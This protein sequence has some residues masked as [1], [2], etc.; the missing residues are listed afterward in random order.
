V[1]TKHLTDE[2][3]TW[4]EKDP[5]MELIKYTIKGLRGTNYSRLRLVSE[6]FEKDH[7]TVFDSQLIYSTLVQE[8]GIN[9]G[10]IDATVGGTITIDADIANNIVDIENNL[11]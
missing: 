3:Q 7:G 11:T 4:V 9:S 1:F 8:D 10:L 6:D 2:T 5:L